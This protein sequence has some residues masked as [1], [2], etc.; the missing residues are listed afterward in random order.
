VKDPAA[1][2]LREIRACDICAKDLEHGV[3]PV[4]QVHPSAR[5]LIAAQA[6]GR[7]VHE[8]GVPFDD[9]SGDRLRRWLGLARGTFYDPR[10]V[11][12]VPMGFC[13]PG[14]GA[15]GDLPPRRECAPRWR[16]PL[17]ALLPDVRLTVVIGQYAA[18]YHLPDECHGLT[19][20]VRNWRRYWPDVVPLPHPSPTNN[21]WLAKHPWF[22]Q[23]LVPPLQRR[24]AEVLAGD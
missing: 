20:A 21:R 3:R 8:S 24:V 18:A 5:I 1:A 23:E 13:Y 9:A 11:A 14:K 4:L 10:R 12:I 22:E 15:S 17:L 6:P 16:E 2:L 7:K 19:Q